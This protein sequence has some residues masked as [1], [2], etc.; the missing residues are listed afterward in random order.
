MSVTLDQVSKRK[1]REMFR[2]G[3][4]KGASGGAFPET[5][6]DDLDFQEGVSAGRCAA[7]NFMAEV[8]AREGLPE[9]SIIRLQ[10]AESVPEEVRPAHIVDLMAALK[11]SLAETSIT[12]TEKQLSLARHAL[13]LDGKRELSY[14]NHFTTGRGGSDYDSWIAMVEA[15]HA[16]MTTTDTSA[17]RRIFKLTTRGAVAALL[18]GELLDPEDFPDAAR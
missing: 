7:R 11:A 5:M 1:R 14:R 13:G 8:I 4:A 15:G 10:D 16:A 17:A 12:L 9:Y 3:F 2:R 18:D 6:A